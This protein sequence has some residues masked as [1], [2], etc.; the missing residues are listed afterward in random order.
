VPIWG[1]GNVQTHVY[2]YQQTD[3][4]EDILKL[5]KFQ[6]GGRASSRSAVDTT[7]PFTTHNQDQF[8][9]ILLATN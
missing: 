9:I 3:F 1:F 6:T 5:C 8:L 7:A 4:V 2:K